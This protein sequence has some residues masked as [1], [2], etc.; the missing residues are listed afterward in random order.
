MRL[1]YVFLLGQTPSRR[2]FELLA[3]LVRP[4]PRTP[5]H[6]IDKRPESGSSLRQVPQGSFHPRLDRSRKA[7]R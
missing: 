1:P 2:F 4:S 5:T 6:Q 3:T 7:F